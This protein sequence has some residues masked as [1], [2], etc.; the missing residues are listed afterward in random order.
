MSAERAE[1]SILY[2]NAGGNRFVDVSLQTGLRDLTWSGDA[3]VVDVNDDG[4]L[5]L[6]VCRF[7]APN[8]LWINRHDG[9]F[10][11][12]GVLSGTALNSTGRP[13]G[14]MGIALGDADNDGDEDLVL[15]NFTLLG[16]AI[17]SLYDWKSAP[18]FLPK[19]RTIM[20]A[21][22]AWNLQRFSG[23]RFML[24]LGTQVKGHNERRYS[25]ACS[26]L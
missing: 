24:G 13:E 1:P 8:Q 22:P 11:N 25:T 26:V 23:G 5:D 16:S 4:W 18:Q 17:K 14:S 21:N 10:E 9:T 20:V 7:N 12:A 15:G 19:T 6:Y 2:R 3:S